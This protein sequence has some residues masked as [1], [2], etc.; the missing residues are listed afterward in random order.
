MFSSGEG[1][2]VPTIP[3]SFKVEAGLKA[4]EKVPK[5]ISAPLLLLGARLLS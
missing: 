3:H 5:I 2:G 4:S 1:S